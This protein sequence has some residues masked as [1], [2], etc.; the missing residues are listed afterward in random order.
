MEGPILG[1]RFVHTAIKRETEDIDASVAGISTPEQAAALAKRV[2]FLGLMVH[3]HTD[4]EEKA[5]FPKLEEKERNMAAHYLFDHKQEEAL[6]AEVKDLVAAVAQNPTDKASK[7]R[8]DLQR[9]A[10]A[11][12]HHAQLHIGKEEAIV[13]PAVVKNFSPPEQGA[14][15]QQVLSSYTPDQ[16][17]EMLPWIINWLEPADRA[18][19]MRDMSMGMPPPIFAAAKDWIRAGTSAEVWSDLQRRVP[20]LLAAP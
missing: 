17:R 15:V 2:E 18:I 11:L 19:Y 10:A 8:N 4:G 13:I 12:R 3:L 9:R 5:M 14:I 20:D 7:V 1:I 6:L 16:V